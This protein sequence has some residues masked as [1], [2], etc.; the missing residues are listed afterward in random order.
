[1]R[2]AL[3]GRQCSGRTTLLQALG[4]SGT[5]DPGKPVT[6]PVPDARLDRLA[7]YYMPGRTVYATVTFT[8]TPSPVYAPRNLTLLQGAAALA[9]VVDNFATGDLE[10]SFR[11]SE[12]NLIL[13]DLEATERRMARLRKEGALRSREY[14]LLSDVCEHLSDDLPLRIMD[15]K[16]DCMQT[17]LRFG[18]LSLKPLLVICN[19]A[20]TPVTAETELESLT[21]AAKGRFLPVDA[22]FELELTEIDEDERA[23][24]LQSM[25]FE[26]S[27]LQRL[28]RESYA[29]LDM[30]TFFT[31]GKDE[32]RAWAIR[33]GTTAHEA[34][35]TIHSDMARG[36]IRAEVTP[37]DIWVECPEKADLRSRGAIGLEGKDYEVSD[38][39]LIQIRFSV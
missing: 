16:D 28:L 14:S 30:I 22:E 15:M 5:I 32:V 1:L 4:G 8:D 33:S 36:F 35:G 3:I 12:T 21:E 29:L 17:L 25:G 38:G 24:F 23:G 34:A 37:F 26:R 2:I 11:N 27:A 18:L 20:S 13:A 9:L 6:I 39:D 10:D 19:R 7:S 31:V